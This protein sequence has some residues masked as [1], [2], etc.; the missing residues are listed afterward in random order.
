MHAKWIKREAVLWLVKTGKLSGV[1][2][3]PGRVTLIRLDDVEKYAR[4]NGKEIKWTS[5]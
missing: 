5:Y 4:E 3:G 1:R 2:S